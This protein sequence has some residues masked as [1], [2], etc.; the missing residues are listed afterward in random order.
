[1]NLFITFDFQGQDYRL[2]YLYIVNV[3]HHCHNKWIGSTDSFPARCGV[4]N[5][6]NQNCLDFPLHKVL[7]SKTTNRKL[8]KWNSKSEF[9]LLDLL[10]FKYLK[11]SSKLLPRLIWTQTVYSYQGAVKNLSTSI[12]CKVVRTISNSPILCVSTDLTLLFTPISKCPTHYRNSWN[13]LQTIQ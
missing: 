13:P 11:L 10:T 5:T 8:M 7:N 12:A 6:S 1:M 4:Q 3:F 9:R 2:W